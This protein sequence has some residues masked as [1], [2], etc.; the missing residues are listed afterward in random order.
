[1]ADLRVTV[2]P[3]GKLDVAELEAA[4]A[5]VAKILGRPVEMRA[6]APVPRGSEDVAR[7]QHKAGPFLAELR[8]GLAR[9]PVAKIVGGAAPSAGKAPVPTPIPDAVVFVTDLDLYR[10]DVEAVFGDIDARNRVAVFSVR[11]LREAFY[12]RKADPGKQRARVVKVILQAIGRLKG[13]PECREPRCVLSATGA[14]ADIDMKD[15]R[16]CAACGRK[17]APAAPRT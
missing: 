17:L 13:L 10:P 11:R 14:L 5:K 7:G 9:L 4:V 16:F 15:E 2:V 1:M 6:A 12:R 3:V 8:L